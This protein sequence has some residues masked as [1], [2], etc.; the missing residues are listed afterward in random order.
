M[1][2]IFLSNFP[3]LALK[4]TVNT[5]SSPEFGQRFNSDMIVEAAVLQ[6]CWYWRKYYKQRGTRRMS[7]QNPGL[8]EIKVALQQFVYN[9]LL[10]STQRILKITSGCQSNFTFHKA[11]Y[12]WGEVI[13][14]NVFTLVQA[15]CC[16]TGIAERLERWP[17]TSVVNSLL[18][19]TTFTVFHGFTVSRRASTSRFLCAL[20]STLGLLK[21]SLLP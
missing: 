17:P 21:W 3:L 2:L 11:W 9:W 16:G 13:N 10:S 20:Y 5:S 8:C 15:N 12:A 7:G 19:R 14:C 1:H 18:K 6:R 4:I